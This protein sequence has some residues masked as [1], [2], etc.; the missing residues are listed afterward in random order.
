MENC[1]EAVPSG[2]MESGEWRMEDGELLRSH[3]FGKSGKWRMENGKL[4]RSRPFGKN[5]KFFQ[6]SLRDSSEQR[7]PILQ[8]KENL[9]QSCL[10]GKDL[11]ISIKSNVIN[12]RLRQCS[13]IYWFIF[14][15]VLL[16][17]NQEN[18]YIADK[19][20]ICDPTE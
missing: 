19:G 14:M 4:R 8:I 11:S 9:L 18:N 6:V 13:G 12:V 10:R 15:T 20:F 3:P 5:G 16:Q 17:S 2:K 1:G 7:S